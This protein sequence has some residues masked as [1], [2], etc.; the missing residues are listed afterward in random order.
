VR[1]GLRAL[2]KTRSI[3]DLDKTLRDDISVRKELVEETKA[4][5]KQANYGDDILGGYDSWASDE[6]I[7]AEG[8]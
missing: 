1:L 3:V 6:A 5:L 2:E 7:K 8:A 4:L